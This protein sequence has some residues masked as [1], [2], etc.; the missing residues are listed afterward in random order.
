MMKKWK[1]Y[2][3]VLSCLLVASCATTSDLENLQLQVKQDNAALEQKLDSKLEKSISEIQE[4][5]ARI[6][7]KMDKINEEMALSRNIESVQITFNNLKKKIEESEARIR[8]YNTRISELRADITK[9]STSNRSIQQEIGE[10]EGK[11]DELIQL[12]ESQN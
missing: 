7:Q 3:G 9:S 5:L 6:D 1:Y 10:I 12:L 8:S 4:S 2:A 11:M